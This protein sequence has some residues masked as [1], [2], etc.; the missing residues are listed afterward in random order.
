[1]AYDRNR[2]SH[3]MNSASHGKG[4]ASHEQHNASH[5]QPG[6]SHEQQAEPRVAG[7]FRSR[8]KARLR[9]ILHEHINQV[10]AGRIRDLS[11]LVLEGLYIKGPRDPRL[12]SLELRE[13]DREWERRKANKAIRTRDPGYKFGVRQFESPNSELPCP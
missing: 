9:P 1:M 5:E 4:I 2:P 3:G 7:S 10:R 13:I 12:T 6:A 8:P 11:L